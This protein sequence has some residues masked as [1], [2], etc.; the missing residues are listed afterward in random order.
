MSLI[1]STGSG[2]ELKK[3]DS[4]KKPDSL[5]KLDLHVFKKLDYLDCV[6]R[7]FTAISLAL[8]VL[9]IVFLGLAQASYITPLAALY[10]FGG[11]LGAFVIAKMIDCC[12]DFIA[13][14]NGYDLHED[15]NRVRHPPPKSTTKKKSSESP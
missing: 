10:A 13:K 14:K 8:L 7:I 9:T 4:S 15:Y 2:V 5:G 12:Q 11:C 3:L 1:P 6:I